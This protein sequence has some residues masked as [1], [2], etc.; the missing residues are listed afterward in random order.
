MTDEFASDMSD[1]AGTLWLDVQ[2]RVWSKMLA[3]TI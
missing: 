1:S 2:N 3:V